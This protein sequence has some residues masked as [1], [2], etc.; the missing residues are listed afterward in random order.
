MQI[1]YATISSYILQ[2]LFEI[3]SFCKI[4]DPGI[5]SRIIS[6]NCIILY[7]FVQFWRDLIC[8]WYLRRIMY[9][10]NCGYYYGSVSYSS[11]GNS[12]KNKV[13]HNI[14]FTYLWMKR[15]SRIYRQTNMYKRGQP[16]NSH[17]IFPR[18]YFYMTTEYRKFTT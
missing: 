2:C 3:H 16:P 5:D 15:I 11:W 12:I 18:L 13:L 9:S 10:I 4:I 8:R 1:T 17:I 14:S 6:N 7:G